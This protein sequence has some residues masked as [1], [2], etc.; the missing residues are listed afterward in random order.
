MPA[1]SAV[2]PGG[3]LPGAKKI[4]PGA[5]PVGAVPRT[6]VLKVAID[7]RHLNFR[8][9]PKAANHMPTDKALDMRVYDAVNKIELILD[10]TDLDWY[11][12]VGDDTITF[13]SWDIGDPDDRYV[14]LEF[15][16][17]DPNDPTRAKKLSFYATRYDRPDG[18]GGKLP[19]TDQINIRVVL[20]Q[21]VNKVMTDSLFLYIDPG[22]KNPGDGR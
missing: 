6:Y 14:G 9:E 18:A 20:D 7:N 16:Q 8:Y 12:P 21:D 3:T 13:T 2:R 11:F 4:L 17:L 10:G 5:A 15:D 19:N 1:I 22:I